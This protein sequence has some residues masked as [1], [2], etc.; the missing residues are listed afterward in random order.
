MTAARETHCASA[1][2]LPA[3]ETLGHDDR[4]FR[5]FIILSAWRA[6]GRHP[7]RAVLT[8]LGIS[9]GIA[10]VITLVSMG[11]S[12]RRSVIERL[13][14]MGQNVLQVEAGNRAFRG[15]SA[16]VETLSYEDVV[17]IRKDCPGVAFASPQV[18]YRSQ[19]A[20]EGRNWNTKIQGLDPEYQSIRRWTVAEGEFLNA[21]M[22]NTAAKVAVLGQSVARQ[23][24]ST[25]TNPIGETI[26]VTNTPFRVVGVLA[27][28]GAGING[29]DMDDFVI[30]PWTTAQRR[31][32]RINY[33]K[34]V[35]VS[36]ATASTID[37]AKTQ[38]IAL[39]RQ[40]HRLT[41]DQP[42]DF[43]IKDFKEIADQV[44]ETNRVM[45]M[46]L[47]SVAAIA[48]IV[49]GINTMTIMLVSVTERTREIGVRLAVGAKGPH[50][51][52]QFLL[53]AML[54]TLLGGLGGVAMGVIAAHVTAGV[55]DWPPVITARTL[56][57]G[58]G[59]STAV[60]LVF[61]YYPAFLAS[62]MDPIDA[63]RYE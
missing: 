32:V 46:F 21:A 53:E 47:A 25:A 55:L 3:S 17:A 57:L 51:R 36:A 9:V 11:E 24:F 52:S 8:M 26:R 63:L 44:S 23:L 42:D 62:R 61:G 37:A 41:A 60:G 35:W 56:G 40:R 38:M 7:M 4:M 18:D 49:G 59:I 45:T 19:V 31:M 30:I 29:E 2:T 43:N 39:L 50:V 20:F 1:R 14:T 28:K 33:L 15:A 27:P 10:A 6:L 48:L 58:L 13:A 12:A 5:S 16:P 22:V 54:L 34:D